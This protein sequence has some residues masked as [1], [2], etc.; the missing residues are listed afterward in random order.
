MS[1]GPGLAVCWSQQPCHQQISKAGINHR[2]QTLSSPVSTV[3][4]SPRLSSHIFSRILCPRLFSFLLRCLLSYFLLCNALHSA[5]HSSPSPLTSTL[6]S[7][8]VTCS[9]RHLTFCVFRSFVTKKKNISTHTFCILKHLFCWHKCSLLSIH[10][11]DELYFLY[12][13]ENTNTERTKMI[14]EC[15]PLS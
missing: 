8:K 13:F 6:S 10:T 2:P 1:G 5:L 12:P 15:P 11:E 3:L 7:H 9:S 4:C 14:D